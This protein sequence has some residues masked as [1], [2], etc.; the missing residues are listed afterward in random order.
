M[1]ADQEGA[2]LNEVYGNNMKPQNKMYEGF[3]VV[4]L[5]HQ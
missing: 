5:T 1:L 2:I 3:H 4:Q